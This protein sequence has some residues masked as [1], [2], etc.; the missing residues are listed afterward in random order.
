M[1]TEPLYCP[2][3]SSSRF[4]VPISKRARSVGYGNCTTSCWTRLMP[5]SAAV[6]VAHP[7]SV[8]GRIV[9]EAVVCPPETDTVDGTLTIEVLLLVR[10]TV[11]AT[12]AERFNVTSPRLALGGT[13]E[14]A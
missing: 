6:I 3:A 5:S 11:S 9:N 8:P 1:R 10:V 2:G 13:T 7:A 12:G 4:G 14:N